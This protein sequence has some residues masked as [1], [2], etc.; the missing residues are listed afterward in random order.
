[1]DIFNY[2]NRSLRILNILEENFIVQEKYFSDIFRVGKKTIQNEI[3][4]LNAM[5]GDAAYIKYDSGGYLLYIVKFEKYV[6]IK[7][8]IYD[9]YKNF[10]SSKVRLVYIF[11]KLMESK[12]SHT[13]DD[14]AFDMIVSR[15]TLLSDIKKLKDIVKEYK[16]SIIG[17]TNV[18]LNVKGAEKDI[19]MFVIEN[20]YNYIYKEDIFDKED[21]DYINELLIKHHIDFQIKS[22]FIKYL[23]V[24][25]DR[26][27]N[28]FYL[29]FTKNQYDELLN[30][31]TSDFLED[32]CKYIKGK[33]QLELSQDEKKFL[34]ICFAT[35]RLP[36]N[37][38]SINKSL[39]DNQEY[40]QLVAH[41]L[42]EIYFEYG[43]DFDISNMVEEF[44]YH[45][46]FLM[47]R[48]KYGVNYSNNMTETIKEKYVM[49]YKIA[50]LASGVIQKDYG[51][52]ISEA[53][54]CYLA[55]YFE[56]FINKLIINFDKMK[57]LLITQTGSAFRELM[58]FQL[59]SKLK[60]HIY[61]T[62]RSPYENVDY[63]DY[64]LVI[65]TVKKD[66]PQDVRVIFQPEILDIA[67]IKKEIGLMRYID[68]VNMPII[69]GMESVLISSISEETFFICDPQ[70]TYQEN[71]HNIVNKLI[72]KNI[73]DKMF[74]ERVIE[75]EKRSSMIFT[76]HVAFPHVI[77]LKSNRFILSLGVS[78][79]GF[80]DKPDLKLIFLAAIPADLS[81]SMVLVKT[82]DELISMMKD[83]KFLTGISKLKN[84]TDLVH[85]FIKETN[86]YR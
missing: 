15:S 58:I 63:K 47:Q 57:V 43:I 68:K 2:D 51:Y 53:E 18:G 83:E 81:Y 59:E 67:Y 52:Q 38:A 45:I 76:D 61:L 33:Y 64:Q 62:V 26:F 48:Q 3:K 78:E 54:V 13:I 41:I 46:Y 34:T 49:S 56:T 70:K 82:Y 32:I 11:K 9:M 79:D 20:I 4:D 36:T 10:D 50:Q 37:I 14:L 28:G 72:E 65:S 86:L 21:N 16:L 8:S 29:H 30:F 5:L 6:N 75:R 23:T 22:E 24:S 27:A 7:S 66:F 40:K 73:V 31:Y 85:Y 60:E 77:N 17:K 35:M 69:R 19:R 80:S 44:M 42:G 1:M 74:L 25:L 84:Y 12:V 71:L 55:V 39:K